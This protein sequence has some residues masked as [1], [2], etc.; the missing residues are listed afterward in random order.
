MCV[1]DV[2]G[3]ICLSLPQAAPMHTYTLPAPPPPA[4]HTN[5]LP[6]CD[7][8]FPVHS[9]VVGGRVIVLNNLTGARRPSLTPASIARPGSFATRVRRVCTGR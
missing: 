5:P 9:F 6:D 3:N 4:L 7:C 1:D 8:G 2:A